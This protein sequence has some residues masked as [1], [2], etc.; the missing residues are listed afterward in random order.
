MF[1]SYH[2][3]R[4]NSWTELT[5]LMIALILMGGAAFGLGTLWQNHTSRASGVEAVVFAGAFAGT[6]VFVVK[7]VLRRAALQ[8]EAVESCHAAEARFN[9]TFEQFPFSIQI[10]DREGFTMSVNHAWENLFGGTIEDIKPVSLFNDPGI[11]A[12]GVDVHLRAA[13]AGEVITSPAVLYNMAT[14]WP[15]SSH[16]PDVNKWIKGTICPIRSADGMV[17]ELLIVHEDVTEQK[18]AREARHESE[19]RKAAIVE[20]ALDCIISMDGDGRVIEWNPSAEKTFGYSRENA[21]G[22]MLGDLI[23]PASLREL[24][25]KGLKR[26]LTTGAG[27]VIGSKIE[28]TAVRATG[29]EFPVELAIT[30]LYLSD[31]LIFCG[32]LRDLSESKAARDALLKAHSDL[33]KRVQLRTTELRTA[34]EQ[35][36]EN[37]E[38]LQRLEDLRDTLTGMVVHDLRT[39]LTSMLF[40]LQTVTYLGTVTPAQQECLDIFTLGCRDSLNVINDL[41]DIGKM[42][43]GAFVLQPQ[44][45]DAADMVRQALN[46]IAMLGKV[47]NLQLSAQI[48]PDLP[49][50]PS[51]PEKLGRLLGN[52]LGNAIKFAPQAGIVTLGAALSPDQTHIRFWVRDNGVGIPTEAFERIFEKFGQ[53]DN[54]LGEGQTSSGLG[55]AFCKMI[56]EAHGGRIWVESQPGQG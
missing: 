30:P 44:A 22:Q 4:R 6:A 53:A 38:K 51:D 26:F 14:S 35:L 32:V 19:A 15:F 28:V 55:L 31:G 7:M 25:D 2:A 37:Y 8:M 49:I 27:V 16:A 1:N 24:H 5:C 33:E 21:L 18:L 52:L 12:G 46:K 43:S 23:I 36:Q 54:R 50:F 34:L 40:G 20:A 13:L 10:L 3:H 56:A 42:E 45:T 29:E 48:E 39:P 9:A 11:V 47:K 41:L 17:N